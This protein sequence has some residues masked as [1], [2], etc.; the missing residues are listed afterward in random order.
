MNCEMCKKLQQAYNEKDA[1]CF[2]AEGLNEIYR[3]V[4]QEIA[5][6]KT[7]FMS[8]LDQVISNMISKANKALEYK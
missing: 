2:N 6:T 1:K 5:N 4:L 7:H 8:N 3:E